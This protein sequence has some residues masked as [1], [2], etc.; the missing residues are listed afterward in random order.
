MHLAVEGDVLDDFAAVS[1]E[2]GAEVVDRD[3]GDGSHESIGG[4]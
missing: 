1:L 3:A 2:G 4:A